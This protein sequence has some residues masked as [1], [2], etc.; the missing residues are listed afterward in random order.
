MNIRESFI[1]AR[2]AC[3]S[4]T[5]SDRDS[6]EEEYYKWKIRDLKRKIRDVRKEV[7]KARNIRGLRK[8]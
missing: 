6:Y 3:A 8:L 1:N 4:P 2:R 7:A 5:D